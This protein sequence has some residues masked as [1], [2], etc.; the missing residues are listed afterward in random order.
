MSHCFCPGMPL[1]NWL[2]NPGTYGPVSLRSCDSDKKLGAISTASE[3]CYFASK[4]PTLLHS[5]PFS[6][7]CPSY[8][9]VWKAHRYFGSFIY[10]IDLPSHSYGKEVEK[11]YRQEYKLYLTR[12]SNSGKHGN[13]H[14]EMLNTGLLSILPDTML[15]DMCFMLIKLSYF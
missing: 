12:N 1:C 10:T 4:L 9:G 8:P 2:K 14:L 11:S 7:G 15:L 6:T 13:Y 3:K 5:T